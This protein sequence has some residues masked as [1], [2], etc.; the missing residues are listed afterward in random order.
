[1][2]F[3][4]VKNGFFGSNLVFRPFSTQKPGKKNGNKCSKNGE[5]WPKNGKKWAKNG[6]KF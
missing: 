2:A 5:K 6:K 1:M 4:W 3:F